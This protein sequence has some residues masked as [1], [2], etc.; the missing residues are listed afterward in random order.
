MSDNENIDGSG[1]ITEPSGTPIDPTKNYRPSHVNDSGMKNTSVHLSGT[2]TFFA[3]DLLIPIAEGE[4]ARDLIDTLKNI[5]VV[6]P[7]DRIR[8]YQERS[9]KPDQPKE[10]PRLNISQELADK[11]SLNLDNPTKDDSYFSTDNEGNEKYFDCYIAPPYIIS[12]T[13]VWKQIEKTDRNTGEIIHTAEQVTRVRVMVTGKF[14]NADTGTDIIEL[15]FLSDKTKE[16]I[17][18]PLVAIMGKKE[19][20]QH[21]RKND[22]GRLEVQDDELTETN[23]FLR[24]I[25]RY[26]MERL[27][28]NEP[29][30]HTKFKT[31]EAFERIGWSGKEFKK[32]V[33]G[34]HLYKNDAS[35]LVTL[36]AHFADTKAINVENRLA[37]TG[38]LQA[39]FGF[40]KQ[41]AMHPKLRFAMYYAAGALFL[42]PLNAPNS[43]FGIIGDTSIGK[44]WT[45]Q[46]VASMFGNPSVKGDG[47]ILN[48][49]ISIAALNAIL[50]TLTDIPTFVDEITMMSEETK[51]ALTYAIGNGQEALRG[52]NDGNLRSSKMIRTNAIIT[53]EVNIV[54][55]FAH[56]GAA[57]RAFSCKNRPIPELPQKVITDVRNGVLKNYGH[58]MRLLIDKYYSMGSDKV[59]KVFDMALN[60][61]QADTTDV[62]AKRKA[63]YFAVAEV[64]GTLLESI[65]IDNH[66]PKIDHHEVIDSAWNEY[67]IGNPDVPLEIKALADLY[68]Y[69]LAHPKNFLVGK[70]EPLEDHPDDIWGWWVYH[71]IIKSISDFEFLDY[72]R[73]EAEKFLKNKGYDNTSQILDYWRDH[74]LTKCDTNNTTGKKQKDGI[75]KLTTYSIKHFYGHGVEK[76]A[77]IIRLRLDKIKELIDIG[78][79]DDPENDPAR[80]QETYEQKVSRKLDEFISDGEK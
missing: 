18:V 64:G 62:L 35:S 73:G 68:R 79:N 41:V 43:A 9:K 60:R 19:W 63:E 17:L 40:Y 76:K 30:I 66:I 15:T 49:N 72:N 44:T 77:G 24:E 61:L 75:K 2:G 13:G 21:V 10:K 6:V 38:S 27:D 32:F 51:K 57:V 42:A 67:V 65:F 3:N 47:L 50:T 5:K 74:D 55:E 71:K 54:S 8:E 1:V 20:Q 56:N 11:M 29:S 69:A 70:N 58:I 16:T 14:K 4:T 23:K 28:L 26:N 53:G 59:Q 36:P 52:K 46:I 25:S 33:V 48:G 37:P 7:I 34:S 45:L 12:P 80:E 78:E 31:G 22:S 39:W